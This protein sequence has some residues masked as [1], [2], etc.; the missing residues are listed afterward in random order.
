MTHLTDAVGPRASALTGRTLA[1]FTPG[2]IAP[3]LV[4]FFL[5]AIT[6]Y[7]LM[8]LLY[9]S[10]SDAPVGETGS[11]T[12]DGYRRA[13]AP[14]NLPV[15]GMSLLIGLAQTIPSLI[16]A[17]LLAWIVARTD[18]PARGKL[19]VLITLPFFLPPILTAMSWG[20][21]GNA[22]SGLINIA[23]RGLTGLE[24]PLVDVFSFGGIV[25]HLCQYTTAFLFMF[26]VDAFRSMD[27]SL[28]E[29][30][31]MC[32]AGS[33]RTFRRITL[34]LLL[35]I[36][37]SSAILGF[38]RGVE[39]FEAPVFFGER[40]GIEV[41][42]TEI[43]NSIA[44]QTPPDYQYASAI[45]FVMMVM[46]FLVIL[47]QWKIVGRR[48]YQT[49]TGKGYKPRLAALGRWKWVTFGFCVL[50]FLVTVVLPVGQ[51]FVGS[52]FKFIGFYSWD[53]L[54]LEHWRAVFD[55][56]A[57]WRSFRNTMVLGLVG[58][59]VTMAL[60]AVVAYITIRTRWAGRRA[61]D[62]LAW[63]PWLMPGIVLGAG[64]LWAIAFLPSGFPLYGTIWAL[65]LAYVSMGTPVAVRRMS[66]SF[67]QLSFDIEECSRVHGA[68][69]GQTMRR[70]LLVLAW[71][72]FAVGWILT[73]FGIMRELSASILLYSAG[74]EVMSVS[75]LRLWLGGKQEQVAVIGMIMI[76]LVV[77]FRWV[78]LS[79][80]AP[81]ISRL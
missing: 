7:P 23:W 80:I 66:D 65:L 6:L 43:Y 36:I 76:A 71:P 72:A 47:L 49:V 38:I 63:L 20:M 64:F 55:D 26:I 24:T 45:G 22:H 33:W 41:I 61:L 10:L 21:L 75:L 50:Y 77:L 67:H 19:E 18:T 29:A 39:A 30:S 35:P 46:M 14:V 8:M 13:L 57:F 3:I 34:M 78:Q 60:G 48:S 56:R 62:A 15:I 25:W 12:L 11:L 4:A 81:R 17:I 40:A 37:S 1:L 70:I 68:T 16:V 28:E 69:W 5:A 51:L 58:S 27:P 59:T 42:T 54:T 2:R 52:F 9:G 31:R 73:F 53:A 79:V 32:G 44:A 74:S